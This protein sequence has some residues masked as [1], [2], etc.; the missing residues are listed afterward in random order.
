M[1]MAGT[2][3]P[4]VIQAGS[5]AYADGAVF[6]DVH[7]PGYAI[8]IALQHE[9]YRALVVDVQDPEVAVREIAKAAQPPPP[10]DC[11][12]HESSVLLP[13]TVGFRLVRT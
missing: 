1:K 9:H 8:E 2:R 5:F 3:I 12:L 6:W 13:A 11:W 7:R 10:A 4:G